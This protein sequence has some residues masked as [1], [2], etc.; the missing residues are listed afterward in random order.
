MLG[1]RILWVKV[2]RA[3]SCCKAKSH[4]SG[5]IKRDLLNSGEREN[6]FTHTKTL[7]EVQR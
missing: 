1:V 2:V 6:I 3:F 5:L 7:Q 4:L